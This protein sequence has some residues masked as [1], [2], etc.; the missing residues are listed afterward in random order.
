LPSH[1]AYCGPGHLGAPYAP[2][3]VDGDPNAPGFTVANL[4][5]RKGLTPGI[6]RDRQALR[7]SFDDVPRSLDTGTTTAID[8]FQAQALDLLTGE[9]VRTAFDPS[10]EP[11]RLRDHY[12][13][14]DF[15]QRLLL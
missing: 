7:R 4:A 13:R 10:R 11:D 6:L 14:N 5:L 8:A 1:Q 12:G 2:F 9:K 3:C 15:G